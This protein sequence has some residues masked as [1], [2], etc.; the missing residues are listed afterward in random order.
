MFPFSSLF[1]PSI[2]SHPSVQFYSVL[3]C[4][5]LSSLGSVPCSILSSLLFSLLFVLFVLLGS[6]SFALTL[7]LLLFVLLFSSPLFSLLVFFETLL[8]SSSWI[9]LRAFFRSLLLVHE[10]SFVYRR[11]GGRRILE[12]GAV[13]QSS[14]LFGQ[15][16]VRGATFLHQHLSVRIILIE[17]LVAA[18]IPQVFQRP[19]QCASIGSLSLVAPTAI[20]IKLFFLLSLSVCWVRVWVC[21]S[22]FSFSLCF[23]LLLYRLNLRGTLGPISYTTMSY[24]GQLLSCRK[25]R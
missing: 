17:S 4:S 25:N 16:V 1:H 11:V 13:F 15:P 21:G 19:S 2:L 14:S 6:C 12:L 24:P 5:V 10:F 22:L 18:V 20:L 3:S 8:S 23:S 7:L 9:V